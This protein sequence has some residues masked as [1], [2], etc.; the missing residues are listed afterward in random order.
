MCG[1]VFFRNCFSNIFFLN[2]SNV[3]TASE[4]VSTT[5]SNKDSDTKLVK[6][7][8]KIQNIS[9]QFKYSDQDTDDDIF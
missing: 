1:S 5:V 7:F 3:R 9:S 2:K 6:S 8:F 4:I